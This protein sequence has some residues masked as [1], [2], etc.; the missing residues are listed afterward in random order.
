MERRKRTSIYYCGWYEYFPPGKRYHVLY[1]SSPNLLG[2][3]SNACTEFSALITYFHPVKQKNITE[4]F[5]I[6]LSEYLG[7]WP[8]YSEVEDLS[9]KLE[10]SIKGLTSEI[11]NL[12]NQIEPL[13]QL[14][15]PTGLNLSYT[16]LRN[17]KHLLQQNPHFEP[18]DPKGQNGMVFAEILNIDI[19][20]AWKITEHFWD[21]RSIDGLENKE[22][23]TPELIERIRENF[24]VD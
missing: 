6:N 13:K 16:T 3:D 11:K 1:G 22:G 8:Q 24:L 14:A 15:S 7:T 2:K 12:K 20:L 23:V 4:T 21:N 17:L 9:K 18:L 19:S 10:K 5:H